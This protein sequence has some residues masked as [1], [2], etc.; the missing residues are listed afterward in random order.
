MS[1]LRKEYQRIVEA[2]MPAEWT[3]DTIAYQIVLNAVGLSQKLA[4]KPQKM[5]TDEEITVIHSAPPIEDGM[6]PYTRAVIAAHIAK[7]REPVTVRIG[8][9]QYGSVMCRPVPDTYVLLKG[10]RWVSDVKEF[11]LYPGGSDGTN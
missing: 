5:L 1:N 3:A 2:V 4:D 6:Y 9:V 7:Q 10:E 11:T 8:M